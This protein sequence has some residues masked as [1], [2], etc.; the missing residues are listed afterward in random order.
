MMMLFL[1]TL[2]QS[3]AE[4]T[5]A[6]KSQKISPMEFA[7]RITDGEPLPAGL[8]PSIKK[9]LATFVGVVRKLRRAAERV[10][11]SRFFSCHNS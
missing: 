2:F 9:N 4:L 5:S 8:K 10:S 11:R 6:A 3:V 7:E 1:L